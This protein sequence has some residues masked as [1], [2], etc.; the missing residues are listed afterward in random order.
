MPKGL[1]SRIFA[2]TIPPTM[3]AELLPS[4]RA[5]GMWFR[6]FIHKP[7]ER[8]AYPIEDALH[9]LDADVRFIPGDDVAALSFHL[10]RHA[11]GE[12]VEFHAIVDPERDAQ[13]VESRAQIGRTRRN[14]H[15]HQSQ[16]CL[17]ETVSRGENIR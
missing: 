7:A 13:G 12:D 6:C 10:E 8:T 4:P 15:A 9:R 2:P 16:D 11:P 1:S 14:L 17:L 3:A 5:S